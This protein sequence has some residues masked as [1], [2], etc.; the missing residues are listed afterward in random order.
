MTFK[1]VDEAFQLHAHRMQKTWKMRPSRRYFRY[2]DPQVR[3]W[4][5]NQLQRRVSGLG[6]EDASCKVFS[7]TFSPGITACDHKTPR[8]PQWRRTR[9]PGE[10]GAR[11][12]AALENLLPKDDYQSALIWRA[13]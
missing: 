5:I 13:E 12:R 10:E 8:D 6:T 2:A 11:H 3:E 9:L 4:V 1:M 7:S